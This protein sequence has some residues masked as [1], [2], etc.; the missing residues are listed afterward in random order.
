MAVIVMPCGKSLL[1]DDADLDFVLSLRPRTNS[2]SGKLYAVGRKN[3]RAVLV[4][5]E[6]LQAP[7]T[8][9]VDHVNGNGLDNRRCNIRLCSRSQNLANANFPK[10]VSGYRGVR[11]ARNQRNGWMAEIQVNNRRIYLGTFDE[12]E[13]AARAYDTAAKQYFGP[14]ARLN[15]PEQNVVPS[16]GSF[17]KP[18]EDSECE[19]KRSAPETLE[20]GT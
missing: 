2:F 4:H 16:N 19:T 13:E 11:K 5:R 17:F 7:R 14:F 12:R 15:F 20:S 3:N 8:L 10:G 6:L 9:H 18:L 1:I